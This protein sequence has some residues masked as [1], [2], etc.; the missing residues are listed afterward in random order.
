MHAEPHRGHANAGPIAPVARA[1][2]I[3]APSWKRPC[4]RQVL[5]AEVTAQNRNDKG[6]GSIGATTSADAAAGSDDG[7]FHSV[8]FLRGASTFACCGRAARCERWPSRAPHIEADEVPGAVGFEPRKVAGR[9]LSCRWS[10]CRR[11]L[12]EPWKVAGR[13]FERF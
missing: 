10:S 12:V 9:C 1:M 6:A 7:S 4:T 3:E 11:S 13:G 8:A 2:E 5:G